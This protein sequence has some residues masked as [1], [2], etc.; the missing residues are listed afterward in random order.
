MALAQKD[1]QEAKQAKIAAFGATAAGRPPTRY[2][3][4]VVDP[5]GGMT[6][7]GQYA[8]LRPGA[9]STDLAEALGEC[10]H[11]AYNFVSCSSLRLLPTPLFTYYRLLCWSALQVICTIYI[12]SLCNC[13]TSCHEL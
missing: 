5:E 11:T 9:I 6:E 4:L 13:A 12:H 3:D 1:F 8:G 10:F 2:H 7:E